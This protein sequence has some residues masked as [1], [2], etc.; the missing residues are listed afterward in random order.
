MQQNV[1]L[2]HQ[3]KM[4]QDEVLQLGRIN[5]LREKEMNKQHEQEVKNKL[6]EMLSPFFTPG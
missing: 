2:L 5:K 3:N 4:L 1:D 6:Q